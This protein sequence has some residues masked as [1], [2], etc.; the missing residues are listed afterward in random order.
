M[1]KWYLHRWET[2]NLNSWLPTVL[3]IVRL[4][5]TLPVWL[6]V[7]VMV[8]CSHL[9]FTTTHSSPRKILGVTKQI[10]LSRSLGKKKKPIAARNESAGVC[11]QRKNRTWS[12]PEESLTQATL[13]ILVFTGDLQCSIRLGSWTVAYE[14]S[15][16]AVASN[17]KRLFVWTLKI[18]ITTSSN[19][20]EGKI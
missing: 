8:P 2:C 14:G 20:P 11:W 15:G 19:F 10:F 18:S 9:P 4:G 17:Q 7:W 1:V 12:C 6:I 5:K 13:R 16:T 3:V